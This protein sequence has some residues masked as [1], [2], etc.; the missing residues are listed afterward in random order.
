MTFIERFK[1]TYSKTNQVNSRERMLEKLEII[2]IDEK[3]GLVQLSKEG[4]AMQQERDFNIRW[5]REFMKL[6]LFNK[7]LNGDEHG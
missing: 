7:N 1:G 3:T 4:K 6:P 2:E 5:R